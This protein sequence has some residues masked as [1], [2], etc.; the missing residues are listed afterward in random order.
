MLS[1]G[2]TRSNKIKLYV[3]QTQSQTRMHVL[4]VVGRNLVLDDRLNFAGKNNR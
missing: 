4:T 3:P 2:S 1:V